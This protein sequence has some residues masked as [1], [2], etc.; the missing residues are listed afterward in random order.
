M[1]VRNLFAIDY[2]KILTN[3]FEEINLIFT[4][5]IGMIEEKY[6]VAIDGP[7]SSG[8]STT[9]KKLAH[10]LEYVYIDTGAMYRACAL[11]SLNREIPFDDLDGLTR[12]LD[13]ISIDIRYNPEGNR[14]LLDGVDV[15]SEIRQENISR[16]ASEIAV[17]GIVREKMVNLQRK[18]G[19]KGGVIMDGRDIGTVVFPD[20]DFKFF[21][22]ADV[23]VRAERRWRELQDKGLNE[24]IEKIEEELRWR[25]KNDSSRAIAPLK[26]A[27]DAVAIDTTNLS[28]EEQVKVLYQY[29]KDH[30]EKR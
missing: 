16:L 27:D 7:A 10:K 6:I 14:L 1:Y 3:I 29:I 9:A 4:G 28:I 11:C 25:D 19:E 26:Q 22:T 8:K 18:L 5:K 13:S 2:K 17:I 15:T 23:R 12:M 24:P 30:C 20:A 21:M